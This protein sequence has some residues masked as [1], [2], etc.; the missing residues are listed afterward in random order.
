[1]KQTRASPIIEYARMIGKNT[2][3]FTAYDM[4][5]FTKWWMKQPIRRDLEMS[6]TIT[7]K[8]KQSAS[9]FEKFQQNKHKGKVPTDI[10]Q[11]DDSEVVEIQEEVE[12]SQEVVAELGLTKADVEALQ[13]GL[14]MLL[15]EYDFSEAEETQISLKG[16]LDVLAEV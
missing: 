9:N 7:S 11:I 14:T 10:E 4:T 13:W 2:A 12:Q 3:E 8:S 1:M 16:I 15:G 6:R 5:K